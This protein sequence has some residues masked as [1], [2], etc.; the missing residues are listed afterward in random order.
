MMAEFACKQSED[1]RGPE[2]NSIFL[3]PLANPQV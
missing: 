3:S 2:E 1:R